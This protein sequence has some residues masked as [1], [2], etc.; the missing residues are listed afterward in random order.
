MCGITRALT[1]KTK[2]LTIPRINH[3]VALVRSTSIDENPW[4]PRCLISPVKPFEP[5]ESVARRYSRRH[6]QARKTQIFDDRIAFRP[7]IRVRAEMMSPGRG[8]D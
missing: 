6:N 3:L 8:R 5:D 2:T 7:A 4:A 1:T